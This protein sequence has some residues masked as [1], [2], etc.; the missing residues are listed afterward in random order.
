MLLLIFHL[1]PNPKPVPPSWRCQESLAIESSVRDVP[2]IKAWGFNPF[3]TFHLCFVDLTIGFQDFPLTLPLRSHPNRPNAG[4]SWH[5]PRSRASRIDKPQT[6]LWASKKRTGERAGGRWGHLLRGFLGAAG[7]RG[8]WPTPNMSSWFGGPKDSPPAI[9]FSPLKSLPLSD[10]LLGGSN[11][12]LLT[13]TQQE[14][15]DL[16]K[17]RPLLSSEPQ[18]SWGSRKMCKMQSE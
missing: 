10:Q 8:F 15:L 6:L 1:S 11:Q 7:V 18:K 14:R 9:S 4:A 13:C 3:P 5:S 16:K 12:S 2:T 17:L